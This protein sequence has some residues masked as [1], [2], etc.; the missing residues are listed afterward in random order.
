M[1]D[2]IKLTAFLLHVTRGIRFARAG[3][4]LI[5]VLGAASGFASTAMIAIVTRIVNTPRTG[6]WGVVWAFTA[7]CVALPVF[8]FFSQVTLLDMTQSAILGLR[9]RLTRQVLAA[10]LRHL[11]KL[12][13]ARL[14]AT[15]T[16]DVNEVVQALSMLP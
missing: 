12:G 16:N 8:R 3:I 11:E 5:A 13:A 2:L 9:L 10:P 1:R 4:V 14:L 15:L 7:L 6:A